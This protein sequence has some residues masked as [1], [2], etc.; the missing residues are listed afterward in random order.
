MHLGTEIVFRKILGRL[1]LA[2]KEA[3]SE[4]RWNSD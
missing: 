3:S 2:S 1:D 4:R